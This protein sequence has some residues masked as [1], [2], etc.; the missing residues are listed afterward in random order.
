LGI[1]Q[2]SL[3]IKKMLTLIFSKEEAIIKTVIEA[4]T[5]IYFNDNI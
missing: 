3:G 4:Y 1:E 2:A 5:N